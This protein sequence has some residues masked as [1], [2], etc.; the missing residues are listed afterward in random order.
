VSGFLSTG[1]EEEES[2]GELRE[3]EWREELKGV[4]MTEVW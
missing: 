1:W 4:R 2:T 3:V